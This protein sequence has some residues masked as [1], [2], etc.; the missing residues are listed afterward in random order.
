[1]ALARRVG[2]GLASRGKVSDAVGWAE[3]ARA[4]G[5]ESAIEGLAQDIGWTVRDLTMATRVAVTGTK[6]GPPLYESIELLGREKTISRLE[7]AQELLE[8]AHD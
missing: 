1:M 5:I 2:L 4:A 8:S 3:R 6:V 7:G